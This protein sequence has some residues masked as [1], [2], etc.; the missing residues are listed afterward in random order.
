MV[1]ASDIPANTEVPLPRNCFA[2]V[3]D[4]D[5]LAKTIERHL[6]NDVKQNFS[7]IIREYYDW[8]KIAEQTAE[9]YKELVNN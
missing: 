9:V 7:A 2:K 4:V 8:D 5:D 6:R 3:G 1:V